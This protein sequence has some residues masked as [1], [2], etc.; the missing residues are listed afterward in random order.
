[1]ARQAARDIRVYWDEYAF[2]GYLNAFSATIT[3]ALPHVEC[4]SDAGPRVIPENYDY[5]GSFGGFGEYEDDLIDEILNA[6]L[7]DGADHYLCGC[8]VTSAGLPTEN[9]VAYEYVARL[10]SEAQSFAV[11][12][13]AGFTAP[14]QG[15]A[16][17]V[18]GTVLRSATVTGTGNGTGRNLGA[19][20][21]GKKLVITFRVISGTFSGVALKVQESSDDGGSDAYADI[22]GATSGALSAPG[23]VRVVITAATEAYKRVVVSSFTGTDAVV[24]VTVGVAAGT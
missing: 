24:L 23:I 13:A 9:S 3:Q 14:F 10:A 15:N 7:N 18:R 17:V 5:T 20:L 19:T 22:T 16:E 12:G 6:D 1:M 21:A 4:F 11:G 8:P 2:S